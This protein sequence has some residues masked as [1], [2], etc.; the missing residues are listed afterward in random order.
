M[1]YIYITY[2][3]VCLGV[4]DMEGGIIVHSEKLRMIYGINYSNVQPVPVITL[5]SAKRPKSPQSQHG[6]RL[7]TCSA[8]NYRIG[9]PSAP[10]LGNLL[11]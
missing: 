6:R 3:C 11:R 7:S 9:L 5:L 10:H 1:Y 2:V 8:G 4:K